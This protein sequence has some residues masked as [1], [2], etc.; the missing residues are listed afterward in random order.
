M[1]WTGIW[2]PPEAMPILREHRKISMKP[3]TIYLLIKSSSIFNLWPTSLLWLDE[4]QIGAWGV[5]Q[6]RKI[7]QFL[8]ADHSLNESDNFMG[9][10]LGPLVIPI[11]LWK[12]P[13]I[14]PLTWFEPQMYCPGCCFWDKGFFYCQFCVVV[15]HVPIMTDPY[16]LHGVTFPRRFK[17]NIY[18]RGQSSFKLK[19]LL[20]LGGK[21][22]CMLIMVDWLGALYRYIHTYTHTNVCVCVQLI[23]YIMWLT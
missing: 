9:T 5:P 13:P 6:I 3:C 14:C 7:A 15:A 11:H 18:D 1:V 16:N 2:G 17:A 8:S 4:F 19:E 20:P 21:F 10:L 12:M 23:S 22:E